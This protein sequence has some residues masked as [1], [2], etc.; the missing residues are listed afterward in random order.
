ML[1]FV[2]RHVNMNHDALLKLGMV[3]MRPRFRV[4]INV[5]CEN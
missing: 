3:K 4:P 1:F 5:A 2:E